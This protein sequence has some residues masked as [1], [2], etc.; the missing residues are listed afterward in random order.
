MSMKQKMFETTSQGS[1]RE[2]KP[3]GYAIMGAGAILAILLISTL[4]SGFYVVGA[5]ERAVIVSSFTGV[6]EEA[7]GE[8][9]HLKTPFVE[10]ATIYDVKE[11]VYKS[12]EEAAS[13][14]L[15]EVETEL[16][17]R[18]HPIPGSVWMIHQ[19]LGVD[20]AER[21]IEP[22]VSEAV[23]SAT[24]MYTA[25]ELISKRPE[26][27]GVIKDVLTQRLSEKNLVLDE[28]DITNFEFS[29]QFV[30]AVEAKLVE[31]Q[32]SLQE[33]N[34]LERVRYE[35]EQKVVRAQADADAIE[36]N[37][38]AEANKTR[39]INSQLA[40]SPMYLQYLYL[41]TWNGELPQFYGG[42]SQVELLYAPN[43]SQE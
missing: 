17:V 5:G 37:A 13:R 32:R 12:S 16:T 40:Q 15:Q 26:V 8:G 33:K 9:I 20:Y 10:K 23:K 14:D 27:K 19:N 35:S 38:Q 34:R 6:E 41:Q 28:V 3:A 4:L 18:Y 24:A 30:A 39:L 43:W 11:T 36:L 1:I 21:V 7:H 29:E 2:V 42:G 31:E 25:E 22:A